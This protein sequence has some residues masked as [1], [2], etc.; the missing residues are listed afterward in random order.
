MKKF[1]ELDYSEREE[2]SQLFANWLKD[3]T[4]EVIVKVLEKREEIMS[5]EFTMKMLKELN[6]RESREAIEFQSSISQ[7]LENYDYMKRF[8]PHNHCTTH[9]KSYRDV[10]YDMYIK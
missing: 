6:E 4:H 2:V 5:N 7:L 9:S 1:N 3:Y 10:L 8:N